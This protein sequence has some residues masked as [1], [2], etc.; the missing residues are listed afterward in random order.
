M[1][2]P[3]VV[4]TKSNLLGR[5]MAAGFGRT[6]PFAQAIRAKRGLVGAEALVSQ[7]SRSGLPQDWQGLLIRRS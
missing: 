5:V 3:Q 6:G 7:S 2:Q 1:V 4:T